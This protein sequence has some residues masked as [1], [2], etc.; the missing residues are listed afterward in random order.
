MTTPGSPSFGT[1]WLDDVTVKRSM[2]GAAL[3]KPKKNSRRSF[4]DEHGALLR[5]KSLNL[6]GWWR[7]PFPSLSAQVMHM[8]ELAPLDQVPGRIASMLSKMTVDD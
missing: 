3:V 6:D 4:D 8:P 5:R 1:L 7:S 2:L